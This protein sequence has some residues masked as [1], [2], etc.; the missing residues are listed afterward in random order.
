MVETRKVQKTKKQHYVP[1]CYLEAW[2]IPGKYQVHVFD[3]KRKVSRINSINDIASERY[4]YDVNP[5]KLF[6]EET[7]KKLEEIGLTCDI[8]GESQGIEHTFAILVD[9]QLSKIITDIVEKSVKRHTFHL[10]FIPFISKEKKAELAAYLAIQDARTKHIRSN[11]E[12]IAIVLSKA[13]KDMG[14]PDEQA[15]QFILPKEEVKNVH[16]S[17]LMDMDFLSKTALSLCRL[18]W[19]F[20][21]NRTNK[22]FYTSDSPIVLQGHIKHPLMSMSGFSS[23]GVEVF[24]PVSPNHILVMFDGSFHTQN[25]H[26]ERKYVEIRNEEFVDYYNSLLAL[27]CESCIYSQDGNMDF[28]LDMQKDNPEIFDMPHIQLQWGGNTYIP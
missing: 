7:L 19:I 2:A 15:Q 17:M 5:K 8:D 28:L 26:L 21:I 20:C 9:T 3:K 11:I 1:R 27:N 16:T 23:K 13:F 18:T 6:S 14:I 12:N 25:A 24:F 10:R 4:F 22:K